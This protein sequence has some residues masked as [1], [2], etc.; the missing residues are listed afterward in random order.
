VL[1]THSHHHEGGQECGEA[2][3][4]GHSVPRSRPVIPR[5]TLAKRAAQREEW[6]KRALLSWNRAANAPNAPP[7]ATWGSLSLVLEVLQ[8]SERMR[9]LNQV[10]RQCQRLV[11]EYPADP[12]SHYHLGVA[13][14]GLD[15]FAQ[16]ETAAR[17]LEKAVFL[18]PDLSVAQVAL[19]RAYNALGKPAKVDAIRYR[20]LLL[21]PELP[22]P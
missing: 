3:S 17:T 4:D 14:L 8:G 20:M 11:R 21:E 12:W 22:V 9:Q 18:N 16:T 19:A 6:I 7:W 1:A 10:I 13:Q 15:D 2:E 5:A